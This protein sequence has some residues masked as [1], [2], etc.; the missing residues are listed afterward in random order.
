MLIYNAEAFG[1]PSNRLNLAYSSRQH[2]G[3]QLNVWSN[4]TGLM[5]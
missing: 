4:Q 3:L 2:E 1:I 5:F